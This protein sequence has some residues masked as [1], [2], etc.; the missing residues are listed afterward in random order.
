MGTLYLVRH[1]Q[2]SFG[3]ADYD[4]LSPLGEQQSLMLG[5]YFQRQ[6]IRFDSTLSGTLKRHD[7]TYAG[8]C[9]GM[10]STRLALRL[11]GLNEYL[12]EAVIAAVHPQPLQPA[13]TPERYR[14]HFGLLRSGLA[15]WMNATAQPAGMP[16]YAEFVRG[17][18]HA[19]DHVRTQCSGNVLLVSSGGPI[20]CALAQVLGCGADTTI[21]LNF[22]LRNSAISELAF[23]P[24]RLSL[25]TFNTLPHLDGRADWATFT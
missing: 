3:A 21:E 15:A 18:A 20:A 22:R 1:G 25:Q 19:L 12:P 24:K 2:A 10:A 7:Q 13:D 9:A 16:S 23:N 14:Q 11:P 6:G 17:V 5:Q 8:I 4:Q